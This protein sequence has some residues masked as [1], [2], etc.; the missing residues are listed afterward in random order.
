MLDESL[1]KFL[2]SAS[3]PYSTVLT[4]TGNVSA[5]SDFFDSEIDPTYVEVQMPT[6]RSDRPAI[7]VSSTSW[8]PDED[9]SV[10]LDALD[11]YER[12]ATTICAENKKTGIKK[13]LPKLLVIITGK[14]PLKEKYMNEIAEL[15]KQWTWIRCI[16]LWLEAKD[17]PIL[18]GKSINT[19]FPCPFGPKNHRVVQA[20]LT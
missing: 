9:F 1:R 5:K 4:H 17:Y 2:P 19:C 18:L 3:T 6:L 10:L 16:S 15:Q 13:N 12:R 20:H 11:I 14:G 7:L 8:T